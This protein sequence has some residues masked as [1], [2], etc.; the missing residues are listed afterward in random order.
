MLPAV[1]TMESLPAPPT[2]FSM[3]SRASVPATVLMP[4]PL[5]LPSSA[6][7]TAAVSAE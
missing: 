4:V 5:P 7:V 1:L 2:T 6:T 3:E